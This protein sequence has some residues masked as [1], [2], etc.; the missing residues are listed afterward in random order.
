MAKHEYFDWLFFVMCFESLS[1]FP[2]LVCPCLLEDQYWGALL[3]GQWRSSTLGSGDG[4]LSDQFPV[5]W[6]T[7]LAFIG[8]KL[9]FYA[10]FSFIS[11]LIFH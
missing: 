1:S 5:Y 4:E 7:T 9:P 10:I 6:R 11:H 8:E 3:G 2:C